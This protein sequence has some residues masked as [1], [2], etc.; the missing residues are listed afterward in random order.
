MTKLSSKASLA[1]LVLALLVFTLQAQET[2]KLCE[3]EMVVSTGPS[4]GPSTKLRVILEAIFGENINTTDVIKRWGAMGPRHTYFLPN[5]NDKFRVNLPCVRQNFCAVLIGGK[6]GELKPHWYINNI[7]VSTK[8][9]GIDRFKTFR[10]S[11]EHEFESVYP[12]ID[13]GECP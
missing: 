2:K 3:Y 11:S 1:F 10:F 13:D 7:T 5:S 8:G 9:E 6:K 4:K 12:Y